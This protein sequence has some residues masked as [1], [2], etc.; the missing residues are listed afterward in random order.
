MSVYLIKVNLTGPDKVKNEYK[1]K[2]LIDIISQQKI[3]PIIH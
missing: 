1:K 3:I 2:R